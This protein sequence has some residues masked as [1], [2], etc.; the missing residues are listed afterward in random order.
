MVPIRRRMI[1]R[2]ICVSRAVAAG[3]G[4]DALGMPYAVIPNFAPAD[5]PEP[6]DLDLPEVI[7]GEPFI[8]FVGDVT[9]EKGVVD[10]LAASGAMAGAPRLVLIGR[11][12]GTVRTDVPGVALLPSTS[13]A[14]VM[15]A[16]RR[17]LFAVAPSRWPDPCPTVI[18]EAMITGKPVVTTAHGGM[19][20]QVEDG[21]TGF[22]VEPGDQAA[23]GKRMA[24]I[25]DDPALR[26]RLG[27]A[28]RE[29]VRSF[30]VE[31]ITARIE[32]VYHGI[33]RGSR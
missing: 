16:F 2:V 17:C 18:W 10:L 7:G 23:L 32:G 14:V 19:V 30:G 26:R 15:A 28:A 33:G 21:V 12:D 27:E 3:N 13:H 22:L 20:D 5:L 8:L 25:I 24:T 9:A 29:R 4:L 11:A 1:D 31:E 6:E